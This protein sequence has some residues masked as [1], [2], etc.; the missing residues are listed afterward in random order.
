MSESNNKIPKTLV[1]SPCRIILA[2]LVFVGGGFCLQTVLPY[3]VNVTHG[4]HANLSM[5][6]ALALK[7]QEIYKKEGCF[8]CH[9]K[10]LRPIAGDVKRFS[11]PDLYGHFPAMDPTENRYEN[12]AMKGSVRIGPDL[13]RLAGKYDAQQLKTLLVGAEGEAPSFIGSM[14]G[15]NR[16]F[17]RE[18]TRN[19]GINLSWKIRAM[20]Q[21][22]LPISEPFQRSAWNALDGYTQGDALVAYL[23]TLGENQMKYAG[24]F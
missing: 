21:A 6:S 13:S 8:Y 2:A 3:K 10:N 12:P 16:L 7:G 17:D 23:L 24:R 22:G 9:T 18:F 14:H 20:M 1:N 11:N 19:D 5:T 4:S 15:Y